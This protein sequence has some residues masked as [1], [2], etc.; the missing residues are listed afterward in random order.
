MG[1]DTRDNLMERITRKNLMERIKKRRAA[2]GEVSS[3]LKEH[4]VGLDTIIDKILHNME[5]W[6][7]LPE[8]ISRPT[9]INLWGLT[10]V[11]KTDLVRKL[12]KYLNMSKNFVEI[13]LTG[14]G[15]TASSY[16]SSIGGIL[17]GSN[18]ET[19]VPGILLLDEIQ[20][21]RS[22]DEAGK[23][24]QDYK[25]QDV[26]TLLSDGRFSGEFDQRE[27]LLS[28]LWDYEEDEEDEDED[29]DFEEALKK[30]VNDNTSN[31]V[32][33]KIKK[34][35]KYNQSFYTAKFLKKV[36]KLE[37]SVQSI[38]KWSDQ[39]KI[40]VVSDKVDSEEVYEGMDYSKLLIFISGNL[41][42]AYHMSNQTGEAD[43][44]ADMFHDNSKKINIITIK[45]ALR[46]R[47]KPEQIA[48]FG[49]T[50][51]IYP[52]LSKA[53]Y[54]E[55]IE[56][57]LGEIVDRVR[58]KSGVTVYIDKEVKHFIY[59]N[60]V[61]PA[62]GTRPL[63]STI[64]GSFENSLPQFLLSAIENDSTSI[65]ISY[66]EGHLVSKNIKVECRGSLDSIRTNIDQNMIALAALHEAGHAVLYAVLM[67]ISP[68]QINCKTTSASAGG[69]N[70]LHEI[71]HSKTLSLHK[72]AILLG[73][74]VAEELVF[75][76]EMR[77]DGSGADLD[78]A[79]CI[80]GKMVRFEARYGNIACT[81]PSFIDLQSIA[82]YNH[83]SEKTNHEIENILQCQKAIAEHK[84]KE[85]MDCLKDVTM[86]L[87]EKGDLSPEDFAMICAEHN[88]KVEIHDAEKVIYEKYGNSLTEKFGG[89]K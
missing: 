74:L 27:T 50:H 81:S 31:E 24:I 20:R 60:G 3:K 64:T 63:F 52:S 2:L 38:M 59:R 53:S 68:N 29:E 16:S 21:F 70:Y 17:G 37:E 49:N 34:K 25:F 75:G 57:K 30:Y 11:G 55:I 42:E 88:I 5:S 8:L 65:E 56:R 13:Q 15:S 40:Q 1:S 85:N 87:V 58:D 78:E 77:S 73:G 14:K 80:A 71:R 82:Y 61:F 44:D 28:M 18:L 67:G 39:K 32:K 83:D 84:L 89:T 46:K 41:D 62:Q 79:T 51:V 35:K 26:W 43:L 4:F 69:F 72:I 6:Y 36:L 54:Q 47:F 66:K 86:A 23:E 48:R 7:I 9:I 12:V 45:N 10:G 19:G 22:V 33:K 76:T